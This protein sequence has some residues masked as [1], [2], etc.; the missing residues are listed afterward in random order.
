[1]KSATATTKPR[2]VEHS[3]VPDLV[4]HKVLEVDLVEN[5]AGWNAEVEVATWTDQNGDTTWV[6]A[7]CLEAVGLMT[8]FEFP[9]EQS[10]RAWVQEHWIDAGIDIQWVPLDIEDATEQEAVAA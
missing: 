6:F 8:Y 3:V 4:E 10:L 5:L 7:H 1:M 9:D 2:P